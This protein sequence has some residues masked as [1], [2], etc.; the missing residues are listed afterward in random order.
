ML[1]P[2]P[3]RPDPFGLRIMA[4]AIPSHCERPS[5]TQAK[6]NENRNPDMVDPRRRPHCGTSSAWHGVQALLG[7][8]GVPFTAG[9][10]RSLPFMY[11]ARVGLCAV[12]C[13]VSLVQRNAVCKPL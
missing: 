9:A 13:R 11:A 3:H 2:V 8:M 1:R 12:A 10:R 6:A 4:I 5:V 7:S